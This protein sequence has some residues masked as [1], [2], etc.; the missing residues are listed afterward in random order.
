MTTRRIPALLCSLALATLCTAGQT[1][2]PVKVYLMAGQS[3]MEGK[4]TYAWKVAEENADLAKPRDD[5]W[6]VYA[7]WVSGPLRPG[8]GG[9]A[10]NEKA[11]GPELVMGKTWVTN[12]VRGLP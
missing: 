11:F 6:C 1:P 3:N 7:G 5:V 9:Q 12:P 8:W 10:S 2:K 4:A